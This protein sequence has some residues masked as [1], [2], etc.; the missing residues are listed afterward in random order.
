M[1][2]IFCCQAP[3]W[4]IELSPVCLPPHSLLSILTYLYRVKM[5]SLLVT[6]RVE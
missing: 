6:K 1:P 2:V 5:P 3:H 4:P